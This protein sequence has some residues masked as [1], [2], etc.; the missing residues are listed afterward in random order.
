MKY[1]NEKK[2]YF[3]YTSSK[4]RYEK[5]LYWS[6]QSGWGNYESA[7]FF[8]VLERRNFNLPISPNN[9]WTVGWGKK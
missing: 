7:T 5:E 6:N 2:C 4:L 1:N 3:I 8:T 9:K